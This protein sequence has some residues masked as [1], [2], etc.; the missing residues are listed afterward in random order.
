MD[1]V[2]NITMMAR[3]ENFRNYGKGKENLKQ[4]DN[5]KGMDCHRCHCGVC[6]HMKDTC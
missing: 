3:S 4:K 2:E 1:S 6:G 5:P